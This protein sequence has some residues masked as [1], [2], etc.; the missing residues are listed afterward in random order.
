MTTT[1]NAAA[2][3]SH[4]ASINKMT[5]LKAAADLH[6][7]TSR[8]VDVWMSRTMWRVLCQ[9][10]RYWIRLPRAKARKFGWETGMTD[11][12]PYLPTPSS[13]VFFFSW[14]PWPSRPLLVSLTSSLC[15]SDSVDSS[16]LNS[17]IHYSNSLCVVT[18]SFEFIS[19]FDVLHTV[20]NS[21]LVHTLPIEQASSVQQIL[22]FAGSWPLHSRM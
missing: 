15:C 21:G 11:E 2:Q 1:A 10:W 6:S 4:F 22:F 18:C 16:Y 5:H 13:G 9:G 14:L 8:W 17:W 3:Q 20:L 12:L 19:W 7:R